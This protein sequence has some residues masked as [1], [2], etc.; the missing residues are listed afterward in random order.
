M[1]AFLKRSEIEEFIANEV[2][3]GPQYGAFVSTARIE[4]CGDPK[5]PF[6]RRGVEVADPGGMHALPPQGGNALPPGLRA[7]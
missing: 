7:E 1:H 6:R 3:S 2:M 4:T 5:Y